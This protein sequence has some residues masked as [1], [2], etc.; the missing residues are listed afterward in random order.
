MYDESSTIDLD[1]EPLKGG[2]LI[3][4]LVLS[5]DPYL[6]GRMRPAEKKSYNVSSLVRRV[7]FLHEFD[8]M[9]LVKTAFTLG[10]P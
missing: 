10:E 9:Y 3:K 1:N 4:T 8:M 7:P 6:R 5:V 2:V